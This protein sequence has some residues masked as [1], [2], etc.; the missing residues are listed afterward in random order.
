MSATESAAYV[1]TDVESCSAEDTQPVC[2]YKDVGTTGCA[3]PEPGA[4]CG[5]G[6]TSGSGWV[7]RIEDDGRMLLIDLGT[8]CLDFVEGFHSCFSLSTSGDT[9]PGLAEALCACACALE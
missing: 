8:A 7:Y 2:I 5:D 6:S 9:D 1:V 3:P 4:D